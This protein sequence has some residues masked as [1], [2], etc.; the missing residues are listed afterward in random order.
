MLIYIRYWTLNIYYYS[1]SSDTIHQL[2]DI[3]DTDVDKLTNT[4]NT[5]MSDTAADV[6]EKCQAKINRAW[7]MIYLHYAMNAVN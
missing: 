6:L 2:M 5:V 4:F 3:T 7:L 1:R